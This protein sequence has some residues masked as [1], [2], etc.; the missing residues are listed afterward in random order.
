M[1]YQIYLVTSFLFFLL[2]C[3][4]KIPPQIDMTKFLPMDNATKYTYKSEEKGPYSDAD[5]T[6]IQEKIITDREKNCVKIENYTITKSNNKL[7][8]LNETFCTYKNKIE[9]SQSLSIQEEKNAWKIQMLRFTNNCE[10]KSFTKEK[11]FNK[12][13]DV[14][15]IECKYILAG[16]IDMLAKWYIAEDIGLYKLIQ[17]SDWKDP[18]NMSVD[19][20]ALIKYE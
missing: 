4:K 17:I 2:G 10:F 11:I 16:R 14:I 1:K 9:I 3:D 5:N 7:K 12:K 6:L 19:T 18:K 13:R 20:M 8:S 15:H